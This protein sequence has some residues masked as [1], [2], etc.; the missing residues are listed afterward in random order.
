MA[1][2]TDI[3]N[4]ALSEV[5]DLRISLPTEV[6]KQARACSD[7]WDVVREEVLAEHPWN[8][9]KVYT[10]ISRTTETPAWR[11]A[12]AYTLPSDYLVL[13][14]VDPPEVGWEVVADR[15]L[16]SDSEGPLQISYTKNETDPTKYSPGFVSAVSYR[17]AAEIVE[18]LTQSN[19]KKGDVF[20]IYETKLKKAKRQDGREAPPQTIKPG[21]WVTARFR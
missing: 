18:E 5:G 10:S 15:T 1:S 11:W 7:A 6:T 9:A 13:R 3:F 2:L 16:Y 20:T 21:R 17:L 4:R 19:T 12:Y 14:E 8:F